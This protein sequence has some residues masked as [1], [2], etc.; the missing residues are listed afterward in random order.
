MSMDHREIEE[1][2]IPDLYLMNK[3]SGEMRLRF[4]E[5]FVSCPECLD[6]LEET[7][8]FRTAL[9]SELTSRAFR[10]ASQESGSFFR[11]HAFVFA[12]LAIL[13]S[14]ALGV[15]SAWRTWSE[16]RTQLRSRLA[17]ETASL[18]QE[19]NRS[20]QL[21]DQIAALSRQQI[22]PSVFPLVVTRGVPNGDRSSINTVV[23]PQSPSWFI[24]LLELPATPSVESYKATFRDS[25]GTVVTEI[26][27]LKS[28]WG[29]NLAVSVFSSLFTKGGYVVSIEGLTSDRYAPLSTFTFQ[30]R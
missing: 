17:A 26:S 28:T 15:G 4:E 16:E 12:S 27:G 8:H 23:L 14:L 2:N 21:N 22:S 11:R 13:I 29:D 30:V 6:R 20:A 1:G 25:R 9:K 24:L 7:E 5:H 18:E 3:L 10:T 19:K